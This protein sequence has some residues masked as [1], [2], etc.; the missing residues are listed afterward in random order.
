MPSGAMDRFSDSGLGM[1]FHCGLYTLLGGNENAVRSTT[2]KADYRKLIDRFALPGFD[3]DAWVACARSMEARFVLPTARHAE[4][5]CLWDSKLTRFTS[6]R[7]PC[8]RDLIRELS[9]ACARQQM[10]LG[11]YF[12]FET[13]LNE[14][15]DLWNERGMSYFEFITG[16]LTELLTNY[17]P[18]GVVWFDH[19]HDELTPERMADIVDLIKRLQPDCLV[20]NRS[21]IPMAQRKHDYVSAERVIPARHPLNRDI[22]IEC[23]DSMGVKSWG[24]HA[25]ESFW[26]TSELAKRVSRCAANGYVYLL[27]V[28]PTPDG[29]IHPECLVRARGLG[30]WVRDQRPALK[31]GRSAILPLDPNQQQEPAIGVATCDGTT[32]HLHLHEW[33]VADELLVR[34]DGTPRAVRLQGAPHAQLTCTCDPRG[35]LVRHLPDLPPGG[36]APWIVAIE[37]AQAPVPRPSPAALRMQAPASGEAVF[38]SPLDAILDGPAEFGGVASHLNHFPDGRVSVGLLHREGES[39]AWRVT[40][41][42]AQAYEVFAS[43]GTVSDQLNGE[44][45]LECGP[46]RIAGRTWPSEHYS[47]PL[48]KRIGRLQLVA[49][50]N[51][52]VFRVTRAHFSDVHGLS[53][54]PATA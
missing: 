29:T 4:G 34:A 15:D 37:L 40:L 14:G 50:E 45:E 30:A 20:N 24:Y 32:L 22:L 23:C 54:V 48:N 21:N 10:Q 9:E 17:G 16:Q 36:H 33:P 38:L 42:A 7:S 12:N 35:L 1:F 11:L 49:G 47:K 13:W 3:A 26:S 28:E 43:F 6:T 2:S 39:L 5:F 31:A 19:G 46:S 27:N 8:K 25:Q 53:L 51:R 41:P 52:I 44:F 18:I